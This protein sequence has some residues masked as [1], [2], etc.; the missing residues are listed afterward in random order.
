MA[1]VGAQL[2][3]R[4]DQELEL[5]DMELQMHSSSLVRSHDEVQTLCCVVLRVQPILRRRDLHIWVIYN[6]F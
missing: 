4:S 2:C 6:D 3:Q 1:S 5:P